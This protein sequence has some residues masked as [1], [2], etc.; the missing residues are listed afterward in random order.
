MK[1]RSIFI[2]LV[3]FFITSTSAADKKDNWQDFLGHTRA[4][5]APALNGDISPPSPGYILVSQIHLSRHG[6]RYTLHADEIT[7]LHSATH[8]TFTQGTPTSEGQ[9]LLKQIDAF[10]NWWQEPP[11]KLATLTPIGFQEQI[12]LG[13]RMA[14]RF[15]E[16]QQTPGTQVRVRSINS[17]T[18]RT[19]ES[20]A[21]FL[22]GVSKAFATL[23]EQAVQ[24]S[25]HHSYRDLAVTNPHDYYNYKFHNQKVKAFGIQKVEELWQKHPQQ[26]FNFAEK[27]V[28]G[29]NKNDAITL[30][31]SL[32]GFCRLDAPQGMIWQLCAPF[33][34][35]A[36]TE[37]SKEFFSF[38]GQIT[39]TYSFYSVGPAL[40]TK[41]G[42]YALGLPVLQDFICSAKQ[43]IEEPD[44]APHMDLRFSHD[45]TLISFLSVLGLVNTQGNNDQRLASFSASNLIPMSSHV[46][47]Q[48]W[49]KGSDIQLRMMFNEHPISFQVPECDKS[50]LCSWS[51]VREH[52]TQTQFQTLQLHKT[53]LNFR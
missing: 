17:G 46:V 16:L 4:Y 44:T 22:F 40:E 13:E 42:V 24:I 51:R 7:K 11:E 2:M 20:E 12:E 50:T 34:T 37:N 45:V 15:I 36:E 21:A 18:K 10:T 52:Y 6:S 8:L 14:K 47:W 26:L 29:L 43:A 25:N 33:E 38:L 1:S 31:K 32:Y 48:I 23:T 19:Q 3:W 39:Q 49:Q 35:F 9:T 28:Q 27:L 53:M 41:G 30:V 5:P